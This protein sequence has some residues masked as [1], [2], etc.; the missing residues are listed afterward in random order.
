MQAL[1]PI[2]FVVATNNRQMLETNFLA[3]P[4]LRQP[5]PHQLLLQEGFYSAAKAYNDAIDRIVGNEVMVFVHQDIL[6]PETWP[7]Q[8]QRALEWLELEDPNWGVLGCYGET[9]DDGGL[10][11]V[12]STGWGM[13]GKPLERPEAVQTL[14][15]I[16]LILKKTSDLRF[17]D[18][19]PHF[20]MYGADICMAAATRGM[21]SYAIPAFCV[22]NTQQMLVLPKEFYDC[23]RYFQRKWKKFLPIQTSCIRV[24]RS[25]LPMRTRRLREFYLRHI[26]RAVPGIA[27]ENDLRRL[28]EKVQA[29]EEEASKSFGRRVC[30]KR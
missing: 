21:K 20:H 2:T 4:C 1:R 23:Y 11:Y 29:A 30:E 12:Y 14:D 9:R 22:H 10:G 27:R 16:I 7:F 13:V 5:H 17:D 3:S 15:E 18:T 24:T 25:G 8:L 6:L 28:L 19:L 26:R